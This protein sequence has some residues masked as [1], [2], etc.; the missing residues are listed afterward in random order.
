MVPRLMPM[1]DGPRAD[2]GT[3]ERS[4]ANYLLGCKN[5]MVA[6]AVHEAMEDNLLILIG[7]QFG[8]CVA[9]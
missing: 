9:R 2:T 8:R 1:A 6:L 5:C 4:F 7:F 3:R